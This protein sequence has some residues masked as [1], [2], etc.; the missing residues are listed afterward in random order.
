MQRGTRF[1][2]KAGSPLHSPPAKT[3][4]NKRIPRQSSVGVLLCL[5]ISSKIFLYLCALRSTA[6]L[7]HF[8]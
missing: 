5:Q 4:L 7:Y 6:S 2:K 3:F 1:L 8:G